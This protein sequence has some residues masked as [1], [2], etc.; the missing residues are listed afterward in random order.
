MAGRRASAVGLAAA[1]LA[2]GGLVGCTP[3]PPPT[4]AS[5][6][7]VE[8]FTWWASGSEKLAAD[9]LASAFRTAHPDVRFEDAGVAGGAGTAAKD[10]L[11][12]RLANGDPPDT[13]QVHGGAELAAHV[14]AGDVVDLS[15]LYARLGLDGVLPSSIRDLVSVD[16]VPYAVPTDV[17]RANLLWAN[18]AV[19]SAAG[20]PP[21]AAFTTLDDWFAVLEKVK[22][23]G[24]TPLVLGAPWTQLHLL[25]QVLLARLGPTAYS[26][27]WDG[28]TNAASPEVASAIDDFARLLS[29]TNPDRDALDWPDA[30]E[31][32]RYGDAAFMV[33]GDWAQP[34][35]P[36]PVVWAPFPGTAGVD[37]VVVDGFA[38]A[39]DAPDPANAEL[40]LQTVA[41]HD[42]QVA[43][44]NAK[45][46]VPPRTDLLPSE[47]SP[48]AR[49]AFDA[50]HTDRIVLSLTHGGVVGPAALAD[51]TAAVGRLS[52][53]QASTSEVQYALVAAAHSVDG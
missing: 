1:A 41:G 10:V 48:Y 5:Q 7:R 51:L 36:A 11:A 35:L 15:S 23:S 17:H 52:R 14:A 12:S 19:L 2:L 16:G 44:T 22:Q 42:V 20:V 18:P 43:F 26:G 33:M 27:L 37:D 25:E 9:V 49:T 30:A 38:Q 34:T 39:V 13:F 32:L 31:R 40:W 45:G 6:A 29:Y 8:V 3:T 46:A 47:L 4:T 50:F 21:N 24:R 53:G 28:R